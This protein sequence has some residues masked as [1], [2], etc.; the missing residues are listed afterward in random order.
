MNILDSLIQ[1][2]IDMH[3]HPAPDTMPMRV[4][5]LEA[6]RQAKNAGMRA[7]VLKSHYYCT[8]PLATLVSQLVPDIGVIGSV[9]LDYEIGGLNFHALEISAKLGA[10]VV[11]MPTLSSANS[12][13]RMKKS[14]GL[15]LEGEGYSIL[16]KNGKLVPEIPRI[17][18]IIKEY[19]MVLASGHITPKETFALF[20]EAKKAGIQK[21][22]VTHASNAEVV[23]EALSLDDQK[24]LAKMGAIIEHT[25]V[26]IMPCDFG[27]NPAEL[28]EIIKATGAQHCILSSDMGMA[29]TLLP[30]EGMRVFAS[31][32]LRHSITSEEIELMIKVNPTRLLSLD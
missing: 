20:D 25:A 4:D 12:R 7:I 32:L 3:I 6:A 29:S 10:K 8:A 24:Q 26:D 1:G 17:L 2:A 15:A 9:C 5:A 31:T 14:L 28:A 27:K 16:D 21:L 22:V 23:D 30:T 19:N 11:W 13:A 18:S